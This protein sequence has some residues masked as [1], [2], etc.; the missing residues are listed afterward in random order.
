[1]TIKELEKKVE[2]YDF[3]IEP[4][5]I[6]EEQLIEIKVGKNFIIIVFT[7]HGY[8]E[9]EVGGEEDEIWT[10]ARIVHIELIEVYVFND[11]LD[12]ILEIEDLTELEF[13][14][15]K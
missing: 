12:V 3:K 10:V 6:N 8:V 13:K 5:Q 14:I 4:N 9:Q 7:P 15:N 1:M 2:D 11:N